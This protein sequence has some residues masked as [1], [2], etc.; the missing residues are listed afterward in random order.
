MQGD[1]GSGGYSGACPP[2]NAGDAA[3]GKFLKADGSWSIPSSGFTN[4]NSSTGYWVKD[5]TGRIHQWG[6]VVTDINNSTLAVAFPATFTTLAS[7]AV[8]V[9]TRSAT[10]R[11]T[12][13]VDG[14]VSTSGFT[15]SNNGSGGYAYWS[16]DGY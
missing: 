11:I 15:I 13:V 7:I 10:D 4:G 12:F 6:N 1:S 14:S 9:T 3:A 5:P 2:P 16:A 8:V